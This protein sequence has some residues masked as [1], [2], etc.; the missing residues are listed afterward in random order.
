VQVLS[1]QSTQLST[2]Q[3]STKHPLIRPSATFS[4]A[5]GGEGLS[6][7]ASFDA[8]SGGE[9]LSRR[10]SFDAGSEGEG[11]SRRASFD[12]GSREKGSRGERPSKRAAGRR[13]LEE[14]VLRSGVLAES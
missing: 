12:A 8:G 7:R 13:A 3:R 14:S 9:G 11:L 5:S 2:E 1:A 10:A 6:R 4:P